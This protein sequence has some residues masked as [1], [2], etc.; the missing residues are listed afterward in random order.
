MNQPSNIYCK[1]FATEKGGNE[2]DYG[3]VSDTTYMLWLQYLFGVT[4]KHAN[5]ARTQLDPN[6]KYL[7]LP[8]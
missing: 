5:T 3:K 2:S 6:W 7:L 8:I 4:I 1:G